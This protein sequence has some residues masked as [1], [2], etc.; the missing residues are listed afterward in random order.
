MTSLMQGFAKA[1]QLRIHEL[2]IW[3][4]QRSLEFQQQV[5]ATRTMLAN[6]EQARLSVAR[7]DQIQRIQEV[8][9]RA[10][11]V[12]QELQENHKT[13]ITN[14][15]NDTANRR[16]AE[17]ERLIIAADFKQ[18]LLD[19]ASYIHLSVWGIEQPT[20]LDYDEILE[21]SRI[22]VPI[23]AYPTPEGIEEFIQDYVSSLPDHPA[24]V[25]VV[26]DRDRVKDLL[27]TGAN[28]LKVD[29]SE[30]LNALIKMV[31]L[32]NFDK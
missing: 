10:A 5:T 9:I 8:S 6:A 25:Q 22:E 31:E 27:T 19:Y 4:K 13:R 3:R 11:L 28:T 23:I 20:L 2:N 17:Q 1:R 26:N 30:I 15:L 16:K 32:D 24:L 29:P 12:K 18:E 7:A 21:E 14:A